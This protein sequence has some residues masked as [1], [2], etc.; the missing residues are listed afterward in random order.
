MQSIQ[1]PA[2][3]TATPT[4][5]AARRLRTVTGNR[6]PRKC[7]CGCGGQIPRDASIRH[8]VDPGAPKPYPTYLREDSPEF[9]LD[10]P[11]LRSLS[12]SGPREEEG[13]TFTPPSW[14]PR[15]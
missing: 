13:C 4:D 2:P 15:Y 8:V 5:A 9:G 3:E 11:S 1:H 7:S 14:R 12:R 6:W 10:I